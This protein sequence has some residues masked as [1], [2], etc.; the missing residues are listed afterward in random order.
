MDRG[1]ARWS[2]QPPPVLDRL[3]K[4]PQVLANSAKCLTA[5]MQRAMEATGK[6]QIK[7]DLF[8]VSIQK[9]VPSVVLDEE[10]AS[11]LPT[12]YQRV[13]TEADRS[14]IAAALKAGTML[15]FA[16]LEKKR[17]LRIR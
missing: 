16:R 17:S 14:A 7:G 1:C 9:N 10:D 5:Y 8:T 4:R 6:E 11:K 12:E 15:P 3:D 13:K 2:T